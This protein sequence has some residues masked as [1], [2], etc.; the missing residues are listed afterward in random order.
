MM[1][2]RLS[3]IAKADQATCCV[4]RQCVGIRVMLDIFNACYKARCLAI[5]RFTPVGL[6]R[7]ALRVLVKT[8]VR[9]RD[10]CLILQGT[11][12]GVT[13]AFLPF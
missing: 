10:G 5:W 2:C 7:R 8:V 4:L 11:S 13:Q 12:N 3:V 9:S 1:R 6:G